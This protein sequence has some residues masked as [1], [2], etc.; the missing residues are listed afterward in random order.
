M[1]KIKCCLC[2]GDTGDF[3]HKTVVQCQ[4]CG[5]YINTVAPNKENLKIRLKDMLLSACW[6]PGGAERRIMKANIQLDN[7]EKYVQP[8]KVF[9]VGSASGFFMKAAQDRGWEAHGNDISKAAIIWAKNNYDLD[10]HYEFYEDI[11][12]PSDYYDAVVMWNTL[13]HTHDPAETLAITK[14]ILKKGGV[15]YIKIPEKGTLE[16]L[17]KHYEDLHLYEFKI[18]ILQDYLKSIG[19][20]EKQIR[21]EWDVEGCPATEYLYQLEEK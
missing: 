21:K 3:V 9:D 1:D 17:K 18:N 11:D 19:F 6:R 8:G 10:I 12:L 13:E 7:I 14:R 20:V 16:A 4:D 15:V 2:G 5:L